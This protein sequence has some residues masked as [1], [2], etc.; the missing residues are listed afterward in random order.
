MLQFTPP[1]MSDDYTNV[2]QTKW[3]CAH[4]FYVY[5]ILV[6]RKNCFVSKV[7]RYCVGETNKNFRND[8]TNIVGVAVN[9]DLS[10]FGNA[11]GG[12]RVSIRVRS[13]GVSPRTHK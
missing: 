9:V 13:D 6:A 10:C 1:K 4:D 3:P 7:S 5:R 2:A 8:R 12:L 11:K